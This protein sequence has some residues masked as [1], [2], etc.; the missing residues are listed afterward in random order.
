[1]APLLRFSR[2]LLFVVLKYGCSLYCHGNRSLP[3]AVRELSV[4]SVG[5]SSSCSTGRRSVGRHGWYYGKQVVWCALTAWFMHVD[6]GRGDGNPLQCFC[7]GNPMGKG[8][9]SA[10]VHGFAKESDTSKHTLIEWCK[11]SLQSYVLEQIQSSD[12]IKLRTWEFGVI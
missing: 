8:A 5:F 11:R 4:S 12:L 9:R 6:P 10:T 2:R 1:M 7:L 3:R